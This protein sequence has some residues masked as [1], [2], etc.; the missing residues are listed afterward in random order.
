ML[1]FSSRLISN[2]PAALICRVANLKFTD[3][4]G[5]GGVA[6]LYAFLFGKSLVNTLHPAVALCVKLPQ[7]QL[8]NLYF[9]LAWC[10]RHA[11]LVFNNTSKC[12]TAYLQLLANL[13]YPHAF[14]IQKIYCFS[15]LWIYHKAA[16]LL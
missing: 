4:S 11:A 3:H 2:L 1:H 14:C 5:Q 16:R 7:Q 6:D 13:V 8:I 12:V 10:I 9:V 15:F